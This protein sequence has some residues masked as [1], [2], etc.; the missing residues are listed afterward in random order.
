MPIKI[1]NVLGDHYHCKTK[2]D[3]NISVFTGQM[4][5]TDWNTELI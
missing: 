3:N 5:V 4:Q 2:Q 1:Q